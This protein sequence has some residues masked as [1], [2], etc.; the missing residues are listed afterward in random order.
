MFGLKSEGDVRAA[1]AVDHDILGAGLHDD[2]EGSG[3]S[4]GGID[5]YKIETLRD[6]ENPSVASTNTRSSIRRLTRVEELSGGGSA[7]A[8]PCW[9]QE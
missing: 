3:E 2:P 1:F 6:R 5:E 8:C 4:F 9:W 7:Y